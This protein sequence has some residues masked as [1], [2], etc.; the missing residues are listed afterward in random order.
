MIG[1]AILE[2]TCGTRQI[3]ANAKI[4]LLSS[5]KEREDR[6]EVKLREGVKVGRSAF[7]NDNE[8]NIR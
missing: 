5:V 4:T 2:I 7:V 3:K 8:I 6:W 1:R